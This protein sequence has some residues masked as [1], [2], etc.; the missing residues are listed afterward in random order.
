MTLLFAKYKLS[1]DLQGLLWL[2]SWYNFDAIICFIVYIWYL[3]MVW[4]RGS[5]QKET[6]AEGEGDNS[7]GRFVKGSQGQAER[8]G[9]TLEE[10]QSLCF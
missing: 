6:I 7:R 4:Q 5:S 10:Y 2:A 9:K 3:E 1:D 8:A